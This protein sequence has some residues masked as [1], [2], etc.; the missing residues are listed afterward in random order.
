M[1]LVGSLSKESRRCRGCWG[2]V[3]CGKGR[4]R[5]DVGVETVDIKV[6]VSSEMVEELS[7]V[8]ERLEVPMARIVREGIEIR[9]EQ[10]NEEKLILELIAQR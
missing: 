3:R 6:R 8:A 9:L 5:V 4:L 7:E 1:M 10:L 2:I